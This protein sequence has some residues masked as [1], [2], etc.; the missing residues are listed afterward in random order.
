MGRIEWDSSQVNRL[1]I[2]LTEAPGRI[3]RRAPKVL[4]RGALQIKNGMKRD[5]SGHGHLGELQNHI[6][7]DE[8]SPLSY[9]IGFDKE[10]QGH[11]ANIAAF[12]SVNNAAVM[13]HTNSLR[14]E[15]P[16]IVHHLSGA[17]EES[18]LGGDET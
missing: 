16:A 4:R 5:A 15:L 11:L 3:Q 1:G 2:D 14:R 6:S 9:E 13:D 10:G 17:G 8:L 18:V 7:Y 12:G